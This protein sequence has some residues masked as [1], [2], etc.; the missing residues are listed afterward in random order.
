MWYNT[1]TQRYYRWNGSSWVELTIQPPG[2][3]FDKI[4]GKAQIFVSQ[5]KPPYHKGDLWI[6][7]TQNGQAEIKICIYERESG[8]YSSSDWIDTKYVDISDVNG[9]IN[10]YDTS[11][12]QTEVFNKLTNGGRDQGIFMKDGMLCIN[13]NYILA[14][15]L[16]G[17]YINAKGISVKNIYN[18]TTFSIDDS[19]NV[20]INASTFSLSG[21]AVATESYVFQ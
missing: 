14:G 11:L 13:A 4:D 19:G 6:T 18:Q 9:A 10:K 15:T 17:K 5:P 16:A 12:G 8:Y 20:N 21:N 1:G 7:S 2:S 3:V